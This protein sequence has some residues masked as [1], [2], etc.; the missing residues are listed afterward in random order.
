[1]NKKDLVPILQKYLGTTPNDHMCLHWSEMQ[2]K[3]AYDIMALDALDKPHRDIDDWIFKA[4]QGNKDYILV[5]TDINR[6]VKYPLYCEDFQRMHERYHETHGVN[7]AI[8]EQIIRVDH[9]GTA[10]EN[11]ELHNLL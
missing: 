2:V 6:V 5:V 8:V 7:G 3:M 11:L 9:D 10:E 1:M 4:H